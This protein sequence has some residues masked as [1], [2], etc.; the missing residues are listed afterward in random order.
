MAGPVGPAGAK[1]QVEPQ[2]SW[3]AAPS[4]R[5]ALSARP[6]P[7]ALKVELERQGLKA[8]RWSVRPGPLAVPDPPEPKVQP[9]IPEPRAAPQLAQLAQPDPP[10]RPAR[11]V[12]LAPRVPRVLLV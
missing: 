8:R 7:R 12:K 5:V 3:V 10:V 11:K 6:V 4:V 9:E 2:V 1:E